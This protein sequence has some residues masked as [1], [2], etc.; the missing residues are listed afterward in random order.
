[1]TKI[2]MDLNG[3]FSSYKW[4]TNIFLLSKKFL[5]GSCI[6]IMKMA[7]AKHQFMPMCI[8]PCNDRHVD[9]QFSNL[10]SLIVGSIGPSFSNL[11]SLLF[12]TW[13]S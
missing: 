5:H 8:K 10:M 7:Q 1:M 3:N 2:S 6:Y 11:M 12:I 4:V 9:C 13:S